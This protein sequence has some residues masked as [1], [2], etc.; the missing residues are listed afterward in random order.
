MHQFLL[1]FLSTYVVRID[2]LCCNYSHCTFCL[3]LY[4]S[5]TVL[6]NVWAH[7]CIQILQG[8]SITHRDN[9]FFQAT[10]AKPVWDMAVQ[11]M[12]LFEQGRLKGQKIN[13]GS[14]RSK[15]EFK[16]H[17]LIAIRTLPISDQIQILEQVINKEV[18]L[19]DM[20]AI[21]ADTKNMQV[22]KTSFSKLTNCDSW[23]N[24][25]Q[26]YPLYAN[27]TQLKRF[28]SCNVKKGI[29]KSF[30]EFCQRAKLSSENGDIPEGESVFTFHPNS[31]FPTTVRLICSNYLDI[32][33]RMLQ[34]SQ[35][36]F[37]GIDLA[38]VTINLEV[39]LFRQ[40]RG[41]ACTN[42]TPALSKF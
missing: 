35:S 14:L 42:L 40:S 20:K 28:M 19:S 24:A 18:T 22:L 5:P 39:R 3:C 36:T 12:D 21:L 38:I 4:K 27:D 7:M 26:K 29:P 34:G 1:S 37:A 23:E 9:I 8:T 17:H 25:T 41:H 13:L 33:G 11:V 30:E 16:Q 6:N 10:L 2:Y 15:P 31:G 32:N